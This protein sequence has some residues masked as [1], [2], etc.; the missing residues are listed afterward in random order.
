M[1]I[2]SWVW[3]ARWLILCV[4]P[5]SSPAFGIPDLV[6]QWQVVLNLYTSLQTGLISDSKSM[7]TRALSGM[8][9]KILRNPEGLRNWGEHERAPSVVLYAAPFYVI[10]SVRRNPTKGLEKGPHIQ[11]PYFLRDVFRPSI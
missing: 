9:E 6:P 8:H 1:D 11:S 4:C 5:I 3:T 7:P 2:I 10:I